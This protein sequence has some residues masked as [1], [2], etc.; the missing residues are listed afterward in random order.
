MELQKIQNGDKQNHPNKVKA[1]MNV[2][3]KPTYLVY[4]FKRLELQPKVFHLVFHRKQS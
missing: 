2:D 4:V 3:W 1:T